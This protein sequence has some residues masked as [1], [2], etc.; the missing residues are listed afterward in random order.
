VDDLHHGPFLTIGQLVKESHQTALDK[1]WWD[2]PRRTVGDSI[3]LMHSELSECLEEVRNGRKL[4][5]IYV[6]KGKPEGVPIELA[7]VLIRIADFCGREAINLEEALRIKLAY[8]TTRTR[9]HG[10]KAL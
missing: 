1:G 3:A 7:D 9:R 6:E 5:Q 8:N 2:D 4:D 10:G